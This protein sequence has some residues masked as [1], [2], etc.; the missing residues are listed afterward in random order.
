M[1]ED[2]LTFIILS[3][4]GI[5]LPDS[6]SLTPLDPV[7]QKRSMVG[8]VN[9]FLN[10]SLPSLQLPLGARNA[11]KLQDLEGPDGEEDEDDQG[12]A[13]VEIMIAGQSL[14]TPNRRLL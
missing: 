7:I 2:K 9:I 14:R 6:S 3:R 5:D 12:H 10:G 11:S 4:E 8:D 1:D 13:E